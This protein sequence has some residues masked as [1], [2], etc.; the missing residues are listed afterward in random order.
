[1]NANSAENSLQKQ[2]LNDFTDKVMW[3]AR[4][5]SQRECCQLRFHPQNNGKPNTDIAKQ[6]GKQLNGG[7]AT[8]N[9][10][11]TLAAVVEKIK[12]QFGEEMTADGVDVGQLQRERGW[13]P[14]NPEEFYPWQVIYRWLWDV[15]FPREGWELATRLATCGMEQFQ[16][17]DIG[18]IG[19]IRRELD[20]G[21]IPNRDETIVK[22]KKY[23]LV[24][25]L[26]AAGYL[27]LLNRSSKGNYFCLSPSQAFQPRGECQ[28]RQLLYVPDDDGL[29]KSLKFQ[30]EGEE[31]FLVIL[32]E[33]P[34]HLSWVRPDGNPRDF[35]V[36]ESR[37]RE[38]FQQIGRQWNGRVFYK[39]F[40]V[41]E[42][43]G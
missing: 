28:P 26:D 23:A 37:F 21:E 2:F 33:K 14:K 31:Y 20:L 32:T 6:I 11:A 42:S 4:S 8:T 13:K 17:V 18:D 10:P 24:V 22:D 16:M 12:K 35:K 27:L 25:N 19:K 29:A 1:M 5:D 36:D 40:E 9:M 15:K 34:L 41:V 38:I 39:Q 7:F 43:P 3:R 30:D